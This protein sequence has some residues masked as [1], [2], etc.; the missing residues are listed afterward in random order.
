MLRAFIVCSCL[1]LFSRPTLA[2]DLSDASEVRKVADSAMQLVRSNDIPAALNSFKPFWSL[3]PAEID[4]GVSKIVDQRKAIATR[5]GKPVGVQFL[6]QKSVG[7]TVIRLQYLEK[8][9]NHFI[10]WQFYFY[11]PTSRWQFNSFNMDD[12]IRDLPYC[13]A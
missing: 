13:A 7:D 6:D 3:P 10:R 12:Q 4:V 1:F 2:A 9:E 8:F 5:Y 11:K